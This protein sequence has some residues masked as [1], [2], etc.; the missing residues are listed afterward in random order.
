MQAL[1]CEPVPAFSDNYL[2]VVDDGKCAI[3]VDPGD[4][5]AIVAY[6]DRTGLTLTTILITHHHADHIGGVARLLEVFAAHRVV[7][8]GPSNE[9]IANIAHRL[10]EGDLVEIAAPAITLRVLDVPGHTA[11]HIAYVTHGTNALPHT[12]F[13]GDTLFAGGC[14]RLFEGTP[15]QMLNSLDKL[16]AL[17]DD[18][19]VCCAHEYTLAN[20]R[21][22]LT[23]EPGNRAL[24][25]WFAEAS[26]LRERGVPTLPTT[27]GHERLTNPFLR[28]DQPEIARS[29]GQHSGAIPA[30]R[31]DCFARLREWKNGFR[32]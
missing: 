18:T 2:W 11:G 8:Y 10:A 19:A 1:R 25:T 7:V 9:H 26:G 3:A 12:V 5:A 32:S 28:C 21:F 30:N 15:A 4:A 16:S 14:G 6:L 13:C 29:V 24:Q 31:L 22:A 20:L 17:P 27:I 23:A